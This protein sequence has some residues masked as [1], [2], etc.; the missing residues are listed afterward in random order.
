MSIKLA[1]ISFYSGNNN[2][3]MI[4]KIRTGF[5]NIFFKNRGCLQKTNILGTTF[6]SESFISS[7]FYCRLKNHFHV[8]LNSKMELG[9]FSLCA[10]LFESAL[11][12]S[13]SPSFSLWFSL[14][15]G[16]PVSRSFSLSF[17]IFRS[18]SRHSP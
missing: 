12:L 13:P 2:C 10:S 14:P 4:T 11:S 1:A 9:S 6:E 8:L 5:W 15:L 7:F 18:T 17:S 3:A 16:L